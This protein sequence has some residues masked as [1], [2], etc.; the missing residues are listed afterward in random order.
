MYIYREKG[1]CNEHKMWVKKTVRAGF[2]I[3]S[4]AD[5]RTIW[6]DHNFL[7]METVTQTF[8]AT[9]PTVTYMTA[10]INLIRQ[11]TFLVI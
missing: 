4:N 7:Q 1:K 5:T 2:K 10:L 9:R 3:K 11:F 6:Q 8:L